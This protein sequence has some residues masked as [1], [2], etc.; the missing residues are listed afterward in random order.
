MLKKT[1]LALSATLLFT[2]GAMAQTSSA[3]TATAATAPFPIKDYMRYPDFGTPVLSP[4]GKYM[5]VVVP[6][7]DKFNLAVLDIAAR[8]INVVTSITAFDV[9]NPNWVGNDRLI[10]TMG[11]QNSPTGPGQFDGGGLFMVSRDGKESRVLSPTAREMVNAG[12]TAERGLTYIGSIPDSDRE[13]LVSAGLRSAD[14]S[15]IYR[16][17]VTTGKTTLV[18]VDRPA[19]VSS[20][21]LDRNRVPRIAIS[22]VKDELESIVHYRESETSPWTELIRI[23]GSSAIGGTDKFIPLAFDNDNKTLLVASNAGRDT[24]GIFKYDVAARKLGDI[25]AGHPRFDMGVDM[26]GGAVPGL[27]LDRKDR[28]ILGYR[29]AA[30]RA[31]NVWTDETLAKLQVMV[32]AA[33]P[34]RVN[35]L[36]RTDSDKSL[37]SSISDRSSPEYFLFDE[38][39]KTIE[40]VANGM[41]WLTD[42]HLVEQ[43]PFMLKTR[44]GLE[45]PSY[46]FLPANYKPGDKLPT[47]VHVHGGP[48]ARADYWGPLWVGGFGVAEAQ[49]L[50]S[51]GYAV[52][53][54]NFRVSTGL[55]KKIYLAGFNSIGREMSEDHE[56]AAKWA[57]SQGFAD[58]ARMCISG[59]SYGGY[60]T[61]Q[62]LAKTP[63]LFKC[64][65]AGLSVSDFELIL[66]ST[67]GDTAYNTAGQKY[68][69]EVIG[70]DKN[71]GTSKLVSPVNYADKIKSPVF[72]YA[73]ADDIRTPLE[74]TTG[75]VNALKRAGQ[76]PEVLIKKEE[77][78]G[79]GKLE[80]RIEQYEKILDFLDRN[81]GSKSRA[82][83][84]E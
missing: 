66:K 46:Y 8:K 13:V 40:Q 51:R 80:N 23:K 2:A 12:R 11:Q 58:P 63:D 17:D 57:V 56:D 32:D 20:W 72:F 50:A 37:I 52:V 48:F 28:R 60:A 29:V 45:I 36:Q 42:K 83:K 9:L 59:A 65:V 64:G 15:D 76:S 68:W 31:Q 22:S 78:H 19:R 62:A 43:H 73:G 44:D 33:L 4:N 27:V 75:M 67:A 10:F 47:V 30:E 77:G 71:P 21:V 53:L 25:L 61:L 54:P 7:K 34:N 5:A 70:E 24:V 49:L 3:P 38:T 18:T 41:T 84:A 1:L 16:L 81:I 26:Q 35:T 82:T 6:I 14:S 55:G 69:R 74:Q 39:K 79:F